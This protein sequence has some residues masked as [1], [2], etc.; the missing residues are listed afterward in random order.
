MSTKYLD[1][2]SSNPILPNLLIFLDNSKALRESLNLDY[3]KS[4]L[5]RFRIGNSRDNRKKRISGIVEDSE[6]LNNRKKKVLT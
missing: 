5:D 1:L 6:P 2:K 3:K 4:S